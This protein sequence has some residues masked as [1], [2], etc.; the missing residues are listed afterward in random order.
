LRDGI[1]IFSTPLLTDVDADGLLDWI[2][3]WN[4]VQGSWNAFDAGFVGRVHVGLN[5]AEVP[6]G[7]Y[8]GTY[9]DGTYRL[10]LPIRVEE[11]QTYFSLRVYPNP[12]TDRVEIRVEGTEFRYA[13][14]LN[15]E[16]NS[17]LRT[18]IPYFDLKD[19]AAGC[20]F[21]RVHTTHGVANGKIVKWNP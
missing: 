2:V 17:I 9:W 6:W 1:S 18:Q 5:R 10:N 7:S 4:D 3:A 14:L 20:Y 21:Y 13:E 15:L 16:G 11:G 8:L 12:T 19:F